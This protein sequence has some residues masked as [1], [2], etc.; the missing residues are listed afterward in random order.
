MYTFLQP[1]SR[2]R[3]EAASY[4]LGWGTMKIYTLNG[5][6]NCE[7]ALG[8]LAPFSRE[9]SGVDVHLH[10]SIITWKVGDFDLLLRVG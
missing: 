5:K 3:L 7:D 6:R 4:I 10:R 8:R 9:E 2:V 1:R